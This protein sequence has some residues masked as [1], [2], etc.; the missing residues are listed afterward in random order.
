MSTPAQEW[1]GVKNRRDESKSGPGEPGPHKR[2][3]GAGEEGGDFD[4]GVGELAHGADEG[5]N[6]LGIELGAGAALEFGQGLLGGAAFFV[7]TVAGDGVV[8][9]GDSD[10]ARAKG[11]AF[12]GQGFGIAG[13]VE[14]FVVV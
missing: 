1:D 7:A 10:D 11:N 6:E 12:A 5:L 2:L 14:K 4:D 9:I 13:A 8:G 3:G